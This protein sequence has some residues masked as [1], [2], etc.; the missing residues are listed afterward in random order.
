MEHD[1]GITIFFV[2][3]TKLKVAFPVQKPNAMAALLGIEAILKERQIIVEAE[4]T[5]MIIPFTN[6][7]YIQA[8][9]APE[10]LPATTIEGATVTS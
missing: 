7:K 6:I 9:P 8:Y 3:G 4:G 5:L 10:K 1:R 2:D